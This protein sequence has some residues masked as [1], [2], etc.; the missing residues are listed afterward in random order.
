M[1]CDESGI[2]SF[3]LGIVVD[4]TVIVK[5]SKSS[6]DFIAGNLFF[7]QFLSKLFEGDSSSCCFEVVFQFSYSS[8]YF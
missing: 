8:E 2:Q 7:I 3:G 6:S 4:M 5:L 1:M